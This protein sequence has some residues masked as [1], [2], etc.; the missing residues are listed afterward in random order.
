MIIHENVNQM[1]FPSN[2]VVAASF[3]DNSGTSWQALMFLI[4]LEPKYIVYFNQHLECA[5]PKH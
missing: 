2:L 3:L 1:L 5:A 4:V